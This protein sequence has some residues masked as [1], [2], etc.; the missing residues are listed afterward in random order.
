VPRPTPEQLNS[1]NRFTQV[2]L[3]ED[4]VYV[5]E[6]MMIDDQPT[7]YYSKLSPALLMK[8]QQDA[9]RGVGLLMNHNNRQLPVGRSFDAQM[10]QDFDAQGNMITS[11][12]GTFYIDL[13]RN[14]QGGMTTDDIAKGI[15][16]GTIFDTSIGFSADKWDCS[17]C[18]H[19]I[20]DWR[21]CDHYPGE[22]YAVTRD[23]QDVVETCYVLVGADGQGELLE[24]S[25]VYA[26]AC[27]RATIKTN[28]SVDSVS[29]S[30]EGSKLHI[31]ENFKNIPLTATIYQYYTKDG[32]VLFTN[33]AERTNGALELKKRSEQS[34]ELAQFKEVLS[35]FGITAE[36]PEELSATIESLNGFQ[37]ELTNVRG[38]LE[39]VRG[40]LASAH[41]ELE[42]V[43]GELSNKDQV[44]E[45]LTRANEEL[46]AKAGLADTY[47]NELIEQTLDMGVRVHG[48]SFNREL[49]SKF[50]S[51]LS[52]DEIKGALNSFTQEVQE[53]FAGARVSEPNKDA[54]SVGARRNAEPSRA[55]FA[56]EVEFRNFIAEKAQE[57]AK[58]NGVSLK[59]ATKLMFAKYSS[60]GSDN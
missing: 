56:D 5:F 45:E 19:D 43:R 32:S 17:I 54:F 18:G 16:A 4:Q 60:D 41:A 37:T 20:R 28:F 48:N 59:E 35:K 51:T 33:T 9:M 44:I 55:D 52:I 47:R 11:L 8:F 49:F 57:Y 7:A 12:Y 36:T 1:I 23:G 10:R 31:V 21:S 27:N 40:E 38:E 6:N 15:D 53:R 13:G 14:T 26:G 25:L 29:E 2:P 39:T 30:N 22:K 50:L 58:A 3:T 46:A 42:S 34:M 24:N